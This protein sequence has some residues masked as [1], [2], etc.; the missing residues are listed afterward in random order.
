[1]FWGYSDESGTHANPPVFALAGFVGPED[2]WR[3]F[4]HEWAQ[5]LD[6][7]R[8]ERFHMRVLV[9]RRGEFE[10]WDAAAP[11]PCLVP[12]AR[13]RRRADQTLYVR[14]TRSYAVTALYR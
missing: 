6:D 13:L 8:V 14:Q 9:H 12:A 4:E 10:H 5:I 3:E 1:M 11:P 7:E 2:A